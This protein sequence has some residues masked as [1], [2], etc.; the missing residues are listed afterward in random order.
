MTMVVQY[1]SLDYEE[2]KD[3]ERQMKVFRETT[4]K[5]TRGFYHKSIRLRIDAGLIVEF[6]GPLVKAGEP[7]P[8]RRPAA[9]RSAR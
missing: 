4:H 2:Y 8:R 5:S 7:R 1:M 3:L 9:K 6:H